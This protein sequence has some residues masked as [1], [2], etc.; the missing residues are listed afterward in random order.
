MLRL[1]I[2]A[3]VFL[4]VTVLKTV[5]PQSEAGIKAFV[6]SNIDSG[7]NYKQAVEAIGQ[8]AAGQGSIVEVFKQ[9][10]MWQDEAAG[11][12]EE[13]K[14]AAGA[15][16]AVQMQ[17]R[18]FTQLSEGPTIQT[19][20]NAAAESSDKNAANPISESD[21]ELN[22]QNLASRSDLKNQSADGEEAPDEVFI[23]TLQLS[24][25]DEDTDD[26]SK[27]AS[28][29]LSGDMDLPDRVEVTK[30]DLGIDY[31]SPLTGTI[32]DGF[33]CRE[34]PIDGNLKFHYG[35]DIAASLGADIKSFSGGA[36]QAVGYSTIYGNY[37]RVLHQNGVLSFYGHCSKI[38]VSTG[39][40]VKLGQAI[41]A[42]GSTGQSTGPHLHFEVH[43]GDKILNPSYYI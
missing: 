22:V 8:A 9:V 23:Q 7:L 5:Y 17:E 32:T 20:T 4:S 1:L 36:V 41:A 21:N 3:F 10:T 42:V 2:C 18:I 13:E 40:V 30:Y 35:V 16:L 27:E 26:G 12:S 14:A 29:I 43:Y 25:N 37:V 34:H 33:G 15:Y 39:D 11:M 19:Q 6:R 31:A 38:Y 28:E 24:L